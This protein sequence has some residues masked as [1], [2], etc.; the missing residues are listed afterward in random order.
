MK[1]GIAALIFFSASHA[2]AFSQLV[3]QVSETV[4]PPLQV[5]S[6]DFTLTAPLSG[7]SRSARIDLV[8]TNFSLQYGIETFLSELTSPGEQVIIIGLKN[9]KT[10]VAFSADGHGFAAI[11]YDA[12]NGYLNIQCS[13]E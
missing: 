3:C 13:V 12:E 9:E 10:G 4:K 1:L 8:S 7:G 11:D 5:R 6:H 2:F